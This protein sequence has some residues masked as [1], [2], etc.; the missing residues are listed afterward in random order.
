MKRAMQVAALLIG[1]LCVA[2]DAPLR[3]TGQLLDFQNGYVFFTTGDGFRVSPSARIVDYGTGAPVTQHPGPR[4]YA[5]ATFDANGVVTLLELSSHRL[6]PE[7]DMA[8]VAR[9]AVTLSPPQPNPDLGPVQT[10]TRGI[11]RTFT[12]RPVL[13]TFTAQ[14]PPS[15]PLTAT[16]Y[17][18]T[19]ASGWNPQA[20]RLDR[21]D[22]LHF[23]VT[24]RL[25]SG[26]QFRYLFTRGTLETQERGENGLERA[27]RE[28]IVSDADVRSIDD[29]ISRWADDVV[30]GQLPQPQ[31]IPTPY[32]PAPFP[33][34]PPGATPHP[35]K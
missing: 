17:I 5:R 4:M 18:A 20:I 34:L 27:P 23:R 12:G 35:F 19:D 13:V 22:A 21:I 6:P 1:I 16:V 11:A 2:V 30:T 33:N 29:T 31:A 3:V 32:N 10:T 24:R 7:G 8:S 25:N 9:F 14:V 15:T 26:T 28:V